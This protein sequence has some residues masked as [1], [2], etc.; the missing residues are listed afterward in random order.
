MNQQTRE[1]KRTGPEAAQRLR[2]MFEEWAREEAETDYGDEPCWEE[3][4]KAL[5]EGRPADGKPFP[6]E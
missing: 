5:N 3:I 1:L 6:E 2:A 4:K